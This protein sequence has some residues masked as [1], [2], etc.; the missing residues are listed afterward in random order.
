MNLFFRGKEQRMEW[1]T[2]EAM[3]SMVSTITSGA[4]TIVTGLG[5][6]VMALMVGIG[7]IPRIVYKFL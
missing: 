4:G 3:A 6:P 1:V 7:L 2:A 5:L